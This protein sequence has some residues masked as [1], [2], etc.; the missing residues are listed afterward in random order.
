MANLKPLIIIALTLTFLH[1]TPSTQPQLALTLQTSKNM[2]TPGERVCLKGNLTTIKGEP[3]DHG[4]IS[5]H[6]EDPVGTVIHVKMLHSDLNGR[7]EDSFVLNKE[8]KPGAYNVH[9]TGSK[10]GYLDGTVTVKFNVEMLEELFIITITPQAQSYIPGDALTFN[11]ELKILGQA[12][13]EIRLAAAGLPEYSAVKFN[14][15]TL[16]APGRSVMII[17]TS[18]RTPIGNYTVRVTAIGGEFEKTVEAKI[19]G[20]QPSRCLIVAATH[21]TALQPIIQHLRAYRENIIVKTFT[22]REFI[23]SLH[24]WY[25]TFSPE[26]AKY[27][28]EHEPLRTVIRHLIQPFIAILYLTVKTHEHVRAPNETSTLTVGAM[29]GILVGAVY[30]TPT[31]HLVKLL[32]DRRFKK[33]KFDCT[34]LIIFMTFSGLVTATLGAVIHSRELAVSGMVQVILGSALTGIVAGQILISN[35]WTVW[36]WFIEEKLLFR[37]SKLSRLSRQNLS[38]EN[39]EER[40][41]PATEIQSSTTSVSGNSARRR[42][43][44]FSIRSTATRPNS[45]DERSTC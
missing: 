4:T 3:I 32:T 22:G 42:Q 29:A 9:V 18:D 5:I 6:V 17:E 43:H 33:M 45:L 28:A 1:A 36:G 39:E 26:I 10:Q 8:S 27:E 15:E 19:S 11:I 38:S 16:A 31:I 12:P 2:Y 37:Q 14:P 25:Y 30:V 13:L 23:N 7:F 44:T 40:V 41:E 34:N 20:V 35:M 24:K 21:G